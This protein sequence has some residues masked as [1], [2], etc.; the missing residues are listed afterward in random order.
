VRYIA[1]CKLTAQLPGLR[2]VPSGRWALIE[3]FLN[4]ST[5]GLL[6]CRWAPLAAPRSG[7]SMQRVPAGLLASH[8]M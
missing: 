4:V 6:G 1:L 7:L 8:T 3:E 2:P 5:G